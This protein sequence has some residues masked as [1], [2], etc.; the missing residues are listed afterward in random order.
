MKKE[1]IGPMI[2]VISF[3][4]DTDVMDMLTLSVTGVQKKYKKYSYVELNGG[5]GSKNF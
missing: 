2:T 1:Y 3:N 5:D 4:T